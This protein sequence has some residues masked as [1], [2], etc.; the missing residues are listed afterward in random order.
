MNDQ[1]KHVSLE[2][3]RK[4][5]HTQRTITTFNLP[6]D[7]LPFVFTALYIVCK[8]WRNPSVPPSANHTTTRAC[9]EDCQADGSSQGHP[10]LLIKLDISIY[11]PYNNQNRLTEGPNLAVKPSWWKRWIAIPYSAIVK[12]NAARDAINAMSVKNENAGVG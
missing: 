2:K 7:E 11:S 9:G 5:P 12:P 8:I 3:Y 1:K 6:L 10:D 4:V